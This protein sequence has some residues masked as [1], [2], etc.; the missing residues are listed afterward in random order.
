MDTDNNIDINISF[1]KECIDGKFDVLKSFI[2]KNRQD[3]FIVCDD[4]T[5][6]AG[7]VEPTDIDDLIDKC[8]TMFEPEVIDEA[9]KK[10]YRIW[11]FLMQKEN[12]NHANEFYQACI[13]GDLKKIKNFNSWD[14][15]K[16]YEGGF[17]KI[18]S[19][20]K[21]GTNKKLVSKYKSIMKYFS[22]HC[23]FCF[24]CNKDI[25]EHLF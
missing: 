21:Q 13:D 14:I 25:N 18:C 23:L 12:I 9:Y 8:E 20:M 3:L 4:I 17:S 5:N 7:K 6:Y 15:V 16:C 24:S 22:R 19:L 2:N 11:T 1:L 10:Y